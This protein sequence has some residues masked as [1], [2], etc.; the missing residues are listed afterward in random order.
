MS[1]P[2]DSKKQSVLPHFYRMIPARF[3]TYLLPSLIVLELVALGIL[4]TGLFLTYQAYKHVQ[5]ER[6]Y[7]VS[8]LQRWEEALAKHDTYPQAYYNAA[9]HAARLGDSQKALTYLQKALVL[10]G[11]YEPAKELKMMLEE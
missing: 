10:N 7:E 9:V 4:V 1:K 5:E 6:L 11:N 3:H 2:A 8:Q